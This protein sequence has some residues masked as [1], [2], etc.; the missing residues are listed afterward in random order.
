MCLGLCAYDFS[1]IGFLS[2]WRRI[3]GTVSHQRPPRGL[4]QGLGPHVVPLW[5]DKK[6]R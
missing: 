4:G 5:G 6:Q 2:Y 1:L 3:I